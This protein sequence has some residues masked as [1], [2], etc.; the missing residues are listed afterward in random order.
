LRLP[1]GFVRTIGARKELRTLYDKAL[2]LYRTRIL[3]SVD[4]DRLPDLRSRAAVIARATIDRGD[5]RA[6]AM[7]RQ[8]LDRLGAS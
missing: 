6:F 2:A 1:P 3:D 8:I 5:V 7:G 4:L